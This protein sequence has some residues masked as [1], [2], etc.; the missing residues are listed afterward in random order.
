VTDVVGVGLFG[1]LKGRI[2]REMRDH[3]RGNAAM[4]RTRH[5]WL[6]RRLRRLIT[7]KSFLWFVG[8][9]FALDLVVAIA[10]AIT[11]AGFPHLLPGWTSSE[12]EI[13]L[14]E[15]CGYLIAGQVGLLAVLSVAVG[16][17]TLISQRNDG[18]STNTD[19]RLYY[20]ESLAYESVASGAA[21]LFVLCVQL[22]WPLQFVLHHAS[23]GGS[24][25]VFVA[26]L[27]LTHIGWICVNVA[28]FA[29][30][31]TVTLR[32]VEPT[33]R[34]RMRERFTSNVVVPADLR[35]RLS[36]HLYMSAPGQLIEGAGDAIPHITFGYGYYLDDGSIEIASR[37][38]RPVQLDDVWMRPLGYVLRRWLARSQLAIA[39]APKTI[40]SNRKN[41][42]LAFRP[43]FD[44]TLVGVT[45]LC[46]R[47][48]GARLTSFERW[49][50][51]W[52]FWFRD[53]RPE[54][55]D[56]P[57][58]TNLLEELQDKVI[59]YIERSAETGFR[60]A[61][62]EATNYHS[63]LLELHDSRDDKG[64]PLSLSQIGGLWES[65][66]QQ[67]VRQYRRVIEKA[68]DK[69]GSDNYFINTLSH[70]ITKLLPRNAT[71]VA[72]PVMEALLDIA[73][74][75]VVMLEG[76]FT[77]RTT[78]EVT[79]GE[80]AQPRLV[81]AGSDQ[82]AY[83]A[84]VIDFVGAW[85]GV[86]QQ[87]SAIYDWPSE[88]KGEACQRWDA[89]RTSRSFLQRHLRNSAYLV[90][91]AVWNEDEIGAARYRD[92][93]VR[94]PDRLRPD[95][96]G[97]SYHLK[98]RSLILPD[99]FDVEWS[100]LEPRLTPFKRSPHSPL[101]SPDTLFGVTI[102]NVHSD[103][104]IVTAAVT[105]HW[106]MSGN[107][108]TPA[109]GNAANSILRR[110]FIPG[111]GSRLTSGEPQPDIYVSIWSL[112]IRNAVA[113]RSER[114]SYKAHLNDVVRLLSGMSDSR[115]V[116]GRIYS[117][118]GS[119]GIESLQFQL[120]V[121]LG[122]LLPADGDTAVLARF[123]EIA[124]QPDLLEAGDEAL[125]SLTF[126]IQSY[127]RVV[128]AALNEA[129][130][131]EAGL[132]VINPQAD[133]T[134]VFAR[135]K[136]LLGGV[137]SAIE[138]VQ[139][140]RLRAQQ[141]DP[142][143]VEVFRAAFQNVITSRRQVLSCFRGFDQA[144]SD[145]PTDKIL[146]YTVTGMDKGDFVT[147]SMSVQRPA[148][149]SESLA[150]WFAETLGTYVWRSF[151]SRERE[152][153]IVDAE[154]G[155]PEYWDAVF[156]AVGKVGPDP[157]L[158]V[159]M[160]PIGNSVTSWQYANQ[161]ERPAGR[162]VEYRQDRNSG[163]GAGYVATMDGVDIFMSDLKSNESC[164]MSSSGLETIVY[165]P[166][167]AGQPLVTMEF[168]EEPDPRK[169]KI[170]ARFAQKAVWHR[171][172]VIMFE[173]ASTQTAAAQEPPVPAS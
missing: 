113:K 89:F 18:S 134:Q 123:K 14:R 101:V 41:A 146:D 62:D 25:L 152:T 78:V 38:S 12:S 28:L 64:R 15:I 85:E 107:G 59:G 72:S 87:V 6:R 45:S 9:Y 171:S 96:Q 102:S 91:S 160:D 90:A 170:I 40:F 32:F 31:L 141:I 61:F 13:A 172:P 83:E 155:A 51:R 82:R 20:Y 79:A 147:P 52:S 36:R 75:E 80:T 34:A 10:E 88:S 153:I 5:S 65:P 163:P 151:G 131:L 24:D 1:S 11:Q 114:D 120:L 21:L 17:V 23:L 92:M 124:S 44:G 150:G 3:A 133:A 143:K 130:G 54:I 126:S 105:L 4:Q 156:A 145:Q 129:S 42:W 121:M 7:G 122:A 139:A 37:F 46:V 144:I 55:K 53:A 77:R 135:L 8:S 164:L 110:E 103:Y 67:W 27:T 58:P 60:Q 138:E 16:I 106:Y 116:P 2:D 128:T 119:D 148:E 97:D 108:E 161:A 100:A 104:L 127:D 98:S 66:H 26:F 68:V 84:V 111:E 94:W 132:K 149:L 86:S 19:V 159:P 168:V 157:A 136:S 29:Q 142:A 154:A 74:H 49:L 73:I 69:I 47:E 39:K 166:V 71:G 162:T 167:A 63:F 76:W 112:I 165:H 81:L 137:V 109:F 99:L 117:S 57:T 169:S 173:A 125:Q 30:F 33:A 115:V 70:T 158:L 140:E 35:L 22:F 48:G 118:F 95:R 50:V 93:L 56:L 43:S